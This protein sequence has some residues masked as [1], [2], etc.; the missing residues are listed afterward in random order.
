MLNAKNS[1]PP[2]FASVAIAS[3]SGLQK[4]LSYAIPDALRSR[5][6][7]GMRVLVPLN[8]R[9]ITGIVT[10]V[11]FSSDLSAEKNIKDILDILDEDT[12]FPED[13]ILLWQWAANYYVVRPGELLK[14][15]LPSG[16]RSESVRMVKITNREKTRKPKRVPQDGRSDEDTQASAPASVVP[17]EFTQARTEAEKAILSFL[18]EKGRV[19]TKTLKNR[20]PALVLGRVLERLEQQ[21]AIE[22]RE[23]VPRMP[24]SSLSSL[25]EGST[26][27]L[28][29]EAGL[30]AFTLSLE[31][32]GALEKIIPTLET[33]TFSV[34][35]MQGVTG[36]GKT[37]IYLQAARKTLALGRSALILAPEIA[38]TTQLVAQVRGRFGAQ[39]A[40]LHSGLVP[41]ERWREWHRVARGEA[42]IVVGARSAVFAPLRNL[43][44]I[45]VDEEHDASYKQGE[46][47][48]YNA[49]DLAVMRG[50]I[51]GCPVILGSATP[52]LE[53]HINTQGG[54]YARIELTERIE[55]RP[56]PQVEVID[57]RQEPAGTIFSGPLRQALLDN[58]EAGKQSLLFLNRRGYANYLQCRQCG[59]VISCGQCSVTMTFHL[60][61]RTLQCHYCGRYQPAMD[62]CPA[63]HEPALEGSGFGTEQVEEELARLLPQARSARLDRDSVSRRGT[64][65]RVLNAWQAHEIDVLIGTQMVAKGHD[66]PGVTLVGV[67]RADSSL[68]FP[69]FRA[70]ERTFQVLTQVAGRA[71]RGDDP[72]RVLLQTYLPDHYS[73]RC[74]ARQDFARFA[75][76]ELR[77]RK[78]LGYPP[79][80]RMVNIRCDGPDGEEVREV[81]TRF[82]E[83]FQTAL[84]KLPQ[85]TALPTVLGPAPAPLE[86]VKGRERWQLLLRGEDRRTLHALVKS[87]YEELRLHQRSAKVRV[88]VDVDPYDML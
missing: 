84:H 13:L 74:A 50:Q 9:K 86:R 78:Q 25:G 67:L 35:L 53:T 85:G 83:A 38:L 3:S 18:G 56:L 42:T 80:S 1:S 16:V 82:A 6:F 51:L 8:N 65:E 77:Y 33:P 23:H 71:G 32:R 20:F 70:A 22:M 12:V 39:A 34:F 66:V 79:Y 58:Y 4:E 44:L 31:Q 17:E 29:T 43:G 36:S 72:G 49:R 2:A 69:D 24:R 52:A 47:A 11:K 37:E 81:L 64:L 30:S 21:G 73:V 48:R 15:I 62:N 57:L 55:S 10:F 41:S 88:I 45:V 59:E 14:T 46:G 76:Y 63:C 5:I 27:P 7:P 60:H 19:T 61:G 68:H 26:P 40:V 28:P 75:A 87:T 54:R